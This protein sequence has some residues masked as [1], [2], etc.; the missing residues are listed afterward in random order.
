MQRL[1]RRA[2][3]ALCA[4]GGCLTNEPT[5][6]VASE[7]DQLETPVSTP[8]TAP[9]TPDVVTAPT[10]ETRIEPAP[11]VTYEASGFSFVYPE[12]WHERSASDEATVS[13]EY[14]TPDGR[15]LGT[16]RAWGGLNTAYDDVAAA[17]SETV[18]RLTTAGHEV[19]STRTVTLP[20]DRAG[21]VVEYAL[22]DS[23]VRGSAVVTLAGPWILRLVV[24]VHEDAY[25][26]RLTEAVNEILTSLT[27]TA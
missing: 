22:A 14:E 10:L 20:D 8:P 27:Y 19:R 18:R 6:P 16:L 26:R 11:L 7:P 25:T 24:L 13:L 4:L 1:G 9:S 23:P 15:I 2:F 17:E 5:A 3:L 12:N 21:R